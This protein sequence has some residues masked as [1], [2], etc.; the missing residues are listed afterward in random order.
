M[1]VEVGRRH[2][3]SSEPS[4]LAKLFLVFQTSCLAFPTALHVGGISEN[5]LFNVA[6]PAGLFPWL[7]N[8]CQIYTCSEPAGLSALF[9]CAIKS[10]AYSLVKIVTGSLKR[11]CV[12]DYM[13]PNILKTNIIFFAPAFD[14]HA[15]EQPLWIREVPRW[16]SLQFYRVPQFWSLQFEK[17]FCNYIHF[18]SQGY[19]SDDQ[20]SCLGCRNYDRFSLQELCDDDHFGSVRCRVDD[21]ISSLGCC[22]YHLCI[23]FLL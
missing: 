7:C 5:M 3:L 14:I 9:A 2:Q 23:Q 13:E 21:H 22:S 15:M 8:W 6:I 11:Q 1:C 16:W 17:R 10:I 18:S 4:F 12:E 19:R 20:F